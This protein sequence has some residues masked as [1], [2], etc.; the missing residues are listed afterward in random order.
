MARQKRRGRGE[1]SIFQ[2]KDGRWEASFYLEDGSRKSLYGRTQK[3]ALE[4]LRAAMREQEQ[5]TLVKGSRETVG[6]HIEHWLENVHKPAIRISSYVVYRGILDKHILPALGHIPLQKLTVQQVE[7]FYARKVNE[8]LSAKTIRC[9]HAVLHRALAHAVYSNLLA[10]NVCDIAKKSLP[11]QTRHEIRPLTE[12]QA[13]QLIGKVRGHQLEALLILAITTGMRRGELL[14]LRWQ[15]INFNKRYLQVRRSVRRVFGYGL[16]VSEPKTQAGRRKI[17]LSSFLIGVLTR[18]RV[19]Q[20]EMRL[21][22]G[23]T[24]EDHDL[25]FCNE[26]GSFIEPDNLLVRFKKLLQEIGLPRMRF[27]DLRHSAATILMSMG[28]P[29]KVVQEILGHSSISMTLD[30]Y[31]HVLPSLQEDAMDKM[32]GLFDVQEHQDAGDVDG[33]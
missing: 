7:A 2:R 22:A 17:V 25:V 24:W 8:G 14:A 21:K 31:S 26:R 11:R 19:S 3:E 23:T 5:G 18:H 30:V 10:R 28:V 16:R 9:I 6:Q 13:R 27:H 33:Q 12:E 20:L 1:G 4:K 15:D 29:A 32:S